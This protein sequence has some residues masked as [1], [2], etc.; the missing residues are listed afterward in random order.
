MCASFLPCNDEDNE[1]NSCNSPLHTPQRQ[2]DTVHE[3]SRRDGGRGERGTGRDEGLRRGGAESTGSTRESV[4]PHDRGV[5]AF[6]KILFGRLRGVLPTLRHTPS[7]RDGITNVE[8][9]S[10][11]YRCPSTQSYSHSHVE[12]N[13]NASRTMEELHRSNNTPSALFMDLEYE[14]LQ[15]SRSSSQSDIYR[16]VVG[17]LQIVVSDSGAGISTENQ[18]KLFKEIVQFNPEVLQAGGGSGLGLWIT[19]SI[20]KMH[21]G[22]ISV[23]SAGLGKGSTFT[24]EIDMQRR[25]AVTPSHTL[26]HSTSVSSPSLSTLCGLDT[27]RQDDLLRTA[28]NTSHYHSCLCGCVAACSTVTASATTSGKGNACPSEYL[29]D[30]S[31]VIR[32]LEDID[33][34]DSRN[35][36]LDMDADVDVDVPLCDQYISSPHCISKVPGSQRSSKTRGE[37]FGTYKSNNNINSN[38]NRGMIDRSESQAMGI[39]RFSDGVG[40]GRHPSDSFPTTPLLNVR[41]LFDEK[42]T[43][44]MLSPPSVSVSSSVSVLGQEREPRAVSGTTSLASTTN[45]AIT[46]NTGTATGTIFRGNGQGQGQGQGLSVSMEMRPLGSVSAPCSSVSRVCVDRV[47]EVVY[48]VLVVDDSS[49]NRKMLLKLLRNAGYTCDEADDGVNAVAKV[50]ERM[51]RG[52]GGGEGENKGEGGDK[53]GV[54]EL[55]IIYDAILMDFVMPN[56]DGPTA[57]QSIRSLGY[58]APIFGVTGNTLDSDI[59]HFISKGANAVIPKPFDFARFK[60][61]MRDLR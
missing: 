29:L 13:A 10:H 40:E 33:F 56:M 32:H 20:V 22:S 19:S 61:L 39:R 41:G 38:N 5:L 17:K 12:L 43:A 50:K 26:Q 11:L 36:N 35:S 42:N 53:G 52:G 24:V 1:S 25:V 2:F 6:W 59:T 23:H 7:V 57:T 15:S 27:G 51:A 44:T 8:S 46:T 3:G 31:T 54:S 60:H 16:T 28:H 45:T 14:S 55:S 21:G 18:S 30:Y 47:G 9:G 37:L 4:T 48:D 49:L 34:A 58:T